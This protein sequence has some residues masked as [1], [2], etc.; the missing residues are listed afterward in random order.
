[1]TIT[2]GIKEL[3]DNL[4]KRIADVKAGETIA[5]TEH[6][7]VVAHIVPQGASSMLERLIAEG[8][9]TPP[10]RPK[11]PAPVPKIEPGFSLSELVI[12]MRG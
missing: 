7:R 2:V 6:G 9:A 8:V 10:T 1:M 3:R 11:G 4:S 12:E 5:V